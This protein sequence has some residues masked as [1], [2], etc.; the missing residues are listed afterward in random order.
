MIVKCREK[1]G[2]IDRK[3]DFVPTLILMSLLFTFMF[4][5]TFIMFMYICVLLCIRL[6]VFTGEAHNLYESAR[7]SGEIEFLRKK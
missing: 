2:Q 7:L 4:M 6:C 3:M 1:I 5:Y